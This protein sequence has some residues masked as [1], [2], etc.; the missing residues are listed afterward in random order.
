[1][2]EGGRDFSPRE[3]AYNERYLY[4]PGTSKLE[5]NGPEYV[6]AE[7]LCKRAE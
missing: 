4:I 7:E 5:Y 3:G 6:A 1:M 2:I